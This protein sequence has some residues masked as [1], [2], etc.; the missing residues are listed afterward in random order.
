M[1]MDPVPCRH[2]TGSSAMSIKIKHPAGSTPMLRHMHIWRNFDKGKN[3]TSFYDQI[4]TF[5]FLLIL[6]EI[7]FYKPFIN[8]PF[9]LMLKFE[10]YPLFFWN[11]NQQISDLEICEESRAGRTQ[12]KLS[13]GYLPYSV[14]TYSE[15]PGFI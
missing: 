6:S 3:S 9:M 7:I 12:T 1:A 8:K 10:K 14:L 2:G 5:V 15:L 11:K 4:L 13:W